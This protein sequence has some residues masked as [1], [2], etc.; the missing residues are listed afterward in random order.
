MEK[1]LRIEEKVKKR[2]NTQK[3]NLVFKTTWVKKVYT[4]YYVSDWFGRFPPPLGVRA[5]WRRQED[6][7]GC[8]AEGDVRGGL[9]ETPDRAPVVRD[10]LQ[11]EAGDRHRRLQL[12]HRGQPQR[13]GHL[14]QNRYTGE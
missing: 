13:R 9:R 12:P 11:E 4:T 5:S 14:R 6:P 2:R 3:K 8:S 1:V 10:A 7:G